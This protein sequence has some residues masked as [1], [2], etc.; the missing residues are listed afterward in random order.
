MT[1]RMLTSIAATGAALVLGVPAA[2][3]SGEP[4]R[5]HGDASQAKLATQSEPMIIVRDHGDASQARAD[6]PFSAQPQPYSG[7]V[8]DDGNPVVRDHGDATQAKLATQSEP[9]IIV[10]DHGDA[11]QARADVPFSAQPQPYSGI[12]RDDGNPVVR[13]H[14]DATQAKLAAQSAPS[15]TTERI[16]LAQELRLN[17]PA[18]RVEVSKADSGREIEWPQVGFGLGIGILLALGLGLIMRTLNVRPFAH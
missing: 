3:G 18:S 10:R 2:W 5:D 11:S 9:M 14:G 1:T 12:V 16:R 7:I 17:P 6:V 15:V 13:D 4:Y 8:R